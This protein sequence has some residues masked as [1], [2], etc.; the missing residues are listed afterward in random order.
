MGQSGGANASA[1]PSRFGDDRAESGAESGN[2]NAS[3]APS[4]SATSAPSPEA[5]P[6]PSPAPDAELR[7]VGFA[8][9]ELRYEIGY[10]VPVEEI[11]L[12]AALNALLS[13]GST[14]AVEV[15]WRCVSDGLGGAEYLPEH[16][17]P[18][19]ASYRFE[20]QLMEA[21][22]CD[23]P[24]PAA[25][26]V[27]A[28]PMLGIAPIAQLDWLGDKNPYEILED[29]TVR[30][31]DGC[32]IKSAPPAGTKIEIPAG[33]SV[34]AVGDLANA[35]IYCEGTLGLSEDMPGTGSPSRCANIR[36]A[37]TASI[38]AYAPWQVRITNTDGVRLK[39]FSMTSAS[40]TLRCDGPIRQG[41]WTLVAG[42]VEGDLNFEMDK[43]D[44]AQHAC[45]I[46]SGLRMDG[47]LTLGGTTTAKLDL[48]AHI[49]RCA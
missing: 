38:S 42:R 39:Q 34:S 33:A 14:L 19:E 43:L 26:V 13:D 18:L 11:G 20:A 37:A 17:N 48:R 35:Q 27:Y 40:A 5:S 32:H 10:G 15:A 45:V 21:R 31:L 1:A 49:G 25:I 2:A 16:E 47:T 46:H 24:L 29:G 28:L 36:V 3:A 8:E 7:I 9:A 44:M 12:P 4:A 23:V 22:P 6:S 41:R 30:L